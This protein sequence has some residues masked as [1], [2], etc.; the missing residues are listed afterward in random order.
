MG[1]FFDILSLKISLARKIL[2]EKFSMTEYRKIDPY[3]Y[4]NGNNNGYNEAENGIQIHH[5]TIKQV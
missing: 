2:Q 4:E 1:L 5:T 3:C